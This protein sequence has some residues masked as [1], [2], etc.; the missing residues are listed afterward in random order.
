M[1]SLPSAPA[2][3]IN[4]GTSFSKVANLSPFRKDHIVKV[5]SGSPADRSNVTKG[6]AVVGVNHR[7]TV[8]MEGQV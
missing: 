4:P 8:G 1:Q 5:K 2:H 7:T 6:L 3:K